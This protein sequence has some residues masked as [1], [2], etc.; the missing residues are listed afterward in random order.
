M[1]TPAQKERQDHR[2]NGKYAKVNP[3]QCCGKSAGVNYYSHRL[4]DT[5][6]WGDRALTLCK[7]CA[8]AT[9]HITDV[10]EFLKFKELYVE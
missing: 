1:R 3:C 2:S 4:T 8:V 10:K 5:G 7:K 6:D 9:D